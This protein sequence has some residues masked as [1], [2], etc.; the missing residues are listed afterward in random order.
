MA[1]ALAPCACSTYFAVVNGSRQ[2]TGCTGTPTARTFAPGHDA[3][4]KGFLIRQA[5]RDVTCSTTGI[6]QSAIATASLYGFGD[7]VRAGI[8]RPA[9]VKKTAK[10]VEVAP[11]IVE[12]KVGR[13]TYKGIVEGGLFVYTDGKG[14]TKIAEKFTLI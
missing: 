7:M 4:L 6:T 9:K 8:N 3:K 11:V 10:V 5:G 1:K 2:G 14:D 13:W 12:G